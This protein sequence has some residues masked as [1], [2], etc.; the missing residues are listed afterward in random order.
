[1][2][3]SL[4]PYNYT[5]PF[6]S[7]NTGLTC[8]SYTLKLYIWNGAKAGAPLT[9]TE[10]WTKLNP[11]AS[12]GNDVINISRVIADYIE[13]APPTG[14]TTGF[15]NGNAQWWLK[16]EVVYVTANASDLI[17][18]QYI[19]FTP[20]GRGYSYGNE[21]ENVVSVADNVLLDGREFKV[22][23]SGIFILPL[24][25]IDNTIPAITV[26]SS[27]GAEINENPITPPSLTQRQSS[28]ATQYLWV[29]VS[30]STDTSIEI[31]MGTDDPA[32]TVTL[33]IEDEYKHTPMD[34]VFVNKYGVCQ[35]LTFFKEFDSSL[36]I[37][38]EKYETDNNQPSAGFHQFRTLNVQGQESFK[39]Q[40][41]WV[42]EEMNETFKQ[43]MLSEQVWHFDGTNHI[44]LNISSSSLNYKTQKKDR[45]IQYEVDFD[46]SFN[47]IN[48]I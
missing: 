21:G 29:D 20:F 23:R 16:T 15:I 42:D 26:I 47:V 35:S 22:N 45:L 36:S 4:S 48:N 5:T 25:T 37:K 8:T 43:L 28:Q 32:P 12:T 31:V 30:A 38:K 33:I 39:V 46:Y 17:T 11:T 9:A 14:T 1:M 18:P 3:R 10:S 6:V 41:G 19:E 2:I 40:S 44:P 7:A 24:Y 34:I 13:V 27:P